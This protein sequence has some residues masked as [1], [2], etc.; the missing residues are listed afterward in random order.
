MITNYRGVNERFHSGKGMHTDI[1]PGIANFLEIPIPLDV[2]REIDGVP[3]AGPISISDAFIK[4]DSVS[5][6]ATIKWKA[7]QP[8]GRVKI[9]VSTTNNRK[10]G[11]TDEYK[12]LKE[13]KLKDEQYIVNLN[14]MPSSFYKFILEGEYN[15]VNYWIAPPRK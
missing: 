4:Y 3:F 13:V 2:K 1:M 11:G 5:H 10:T 8:A 9:Y 6:R 14:S 15:T 7:M 12:L